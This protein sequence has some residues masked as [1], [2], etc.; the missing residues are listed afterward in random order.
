M[1]VFIVTDLEGVSGIDR[2]EQVAENTLFAR[3]RL[4]ADVNATIRGAFDGGATEVYVVD[5]HGGGN[6]FLP[7]KLDPRAEQVN[8][9]TPY[10]LE[11]LIASDAIFSIGA[12]AM[13]GTQNAFLDHTQSSLCWHDYYVNGRKFGELGQQAIFAGTFSIP[14]VMVS[15]DFAA[16]AEAREYLGNLQ[17]AVVKYAVKRNEA[18]CVPL[19]EAENAIYAAAKNAIADIPSAKPF[20]ILLPAEIKV[21][22]NRADYCEDTLEASGFQYE[23]LDGRTLRKIITKIET[24][25]DILL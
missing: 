19:A 18:V 14:L 25:R 1:K 21:E 22:F 5:G 6:N 3:E 11:K 15:G 17:T 8:L 7:G 23:R 2:M 13:S 20:R 12:H 10:G 4:M 16:C 24:F 9:I